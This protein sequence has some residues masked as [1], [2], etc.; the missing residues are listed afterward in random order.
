MTGEE[1]RRF[2]V[3]ALS[4]GLDIAI[5]AVVG[6]LVGR[7]YDL[8]VYGTLVGA[9]LGTLVMYIHFIIVLRR[10]RRAMKKVKRSSV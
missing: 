9:L 5:F 7:L 1:Y 6:Y 4:I 3:K 10:M 8:E 2:M